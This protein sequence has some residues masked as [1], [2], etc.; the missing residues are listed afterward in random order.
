M[1]SLKQI[2]KALKQPFTALCYLLWITESHSQ[3]GEDRIIDWLI[4]KDNNGIEKPYKGLY[5]DIWGND[6]VYWNNT[7][8]FY[9]KWW[10]WITIEPNKKL[11]KKFKNK[12]PEDIN[13]QVAAWRQNGSLA[14]YSFEVDAVSTC[15]PIAVK[16]YLDS[17]HKMVDEYTVPVRTLEK[18]CNEYIKDKK[19][20]ILSIDVEGLDMEVLK[21]NNREKYS[22]IYVIIETVENNKNWRVKQ[23]EIF[24]PFMKEKWYCVVA[25]TWVNTIYKKTQ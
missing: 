7:Y 18:I 15:D 6:P 22:P 19:I 21:S 2:K 23:S 4:L 5:I 13:L 20:D 17:W 9:R 24:D 8:F 25:E 11:I 16:R 14:F 10:R 3:F 1:L 12:R